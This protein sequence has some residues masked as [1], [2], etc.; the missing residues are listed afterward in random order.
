MTVE[1]T[2][3]AIQ[4]R[5]KSRGRTTVAPVITRKAVASDAPSAISRL[6]TAQSA[7]KRQ[8][9]A[10]ASVV[11][12][13]GAANENEH[14]AAMMAHQQESKKPT[15]RSFNV[16]AETAD[17]QEFMKALETGDAESIK[18]FGINVDFGPMFFTGT[19][20]GGTAQVS[21]GAAS[22]PEAPAEEAPAAEVPAEPETVVTEAPAKVTTKKSRKA[23]QA[24]ETINPIGGLVESMQ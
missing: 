12:P 8:A 6:L 20:Q 10:P 18:K 1:S 17:Y 23:K 24:V 22:E 2:L 15:A 4:A 11:K 19:D 9:V 21:M 5:S 13:T 7:A 14:I 3:I 16:A